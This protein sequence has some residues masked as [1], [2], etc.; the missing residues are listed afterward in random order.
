[1]SE[2]QVQEDLTALW[3]RV[4]SQVAGDGPNKAVL[5]LAKPLGL[6]KGTGA[7]NLIIATPNAFVKD[8]IDVRL[9]NAITESL[10]ATLN[11]KINFA[12]TVDESL[13]LPDAPEPIHDQE[14]N[15][16]NN[17]GINSGEAVIR[18]EEVQKPAGSDALNPRYIFET[19]VIGA[20]NRFAHAAA[21]AV[22]EAPAKAYNPLF[23]Y[24][25]S[26]LGKTHLLHAIGAYAKELYPNVRVRYVSS[27]EFT[28]DFINSIRDDKSNSFQKRYRDLDILL[29]D[30][31]QFLENKERTQEEFFHTFN[32]LYNANKQIVISSDRPPKQLTTLEDR[33]RSRF[34]WGLITDIQPP[35]LET[36]IA[37]LRKKAAQERLN[38][39]D[40]V[41]EYIASKIF[42]NIRELEG[43]LIRVTAFAS[44][45]RQPVDMA[46][47]EIVLKDLIP[48]D[49]SS[50]INAATIMAQ[51]AA[52]FSLSVDDLCGTSRS[53]VLVN[54]RQIAMYLCRELTELSL[55]KI[56]QQFGGRD[57]TTVMHA[58]RKI[59]ELM[60][61]RRSIYN[62]VNEL[63]SRIKQQ[64]K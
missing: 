40:D 50:S 52:Y 51:T 55:P 28:N 30:D 7:P 15:Q 59:R 62:Q 21:L 61:E 56:G 4:I 38:A 22:S 34:E 31:I 60:A 6:L 29:V 2:T 48:S 3:G 26:G 17:H 20:S 33:L 24:G 47:A 11:E 49:A 37:I 25:E 16:V 63:T 64:G 39:P 9:R 8:I 12:V 18:R 32:T 14:S 35:E 43:A 10:A 19:F 45:N 5:E 23:I 42:T 53:R 41:L 27:E 57:H 13:E 58:D 1:M 54:A 46:L 44:L 36:R